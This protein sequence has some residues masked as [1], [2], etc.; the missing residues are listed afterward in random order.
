METGGDETELL[1]HWGKTLCG[2]PLAGLT[3]RHVIFEREKVQRLRRTE[4]CPDCLALA[5]S[6]HLAFKGRAARA[7]PAEG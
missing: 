6:F 3:A 2:R 4:V 1:K 5:K 7:R